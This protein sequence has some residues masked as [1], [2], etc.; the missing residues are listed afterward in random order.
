MWFTL[1]AIPSLVAT[2]TVW[3]QRVGADFPAFKS[4]CLQLSSL[5]VRHVPCPRD[6]GCDHLVLHRHDG[7][8]AVAACRCNP[9]VCPDLPLTRPDITTLEVCHTR[10]GYALCQAFGLNLRYAEL[11]VPNTFQFGA[12]STDAVPAVLTIQVQRP[13]FRRAVA[14]L[15]AVQRGRF[16][17]FAPTAD[18]LDA[19]ARAILENYGAAFF[20]LQ[21]HVILTE[22]GTLHA[23]RPPGELFARFN[24][25]PKD[26]DSDSAARIFAVVTKLDTDKPLKPPSLL[27]VFRLYC[28]EE[29]SSDQIARRCGTT[30]TTVLRRLALLQSRLAVHPRQLRRLSPHLSKIQDSLH[31]PHA[32]HIHPPSLLGE[33][34]GDD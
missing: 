33:E 23:T 15:A 6:C 13:Y 9:P 14:E 28:V 18:F 8:G 30:K 3:R 17:L 11:P 24:P 10:L 22:H 26:I 19:P 16:M 32:G 21:S 2:E 29:L 31:P 1:E 34:S 12:W 5:Q 27:T 20:D 7:A 25:Q 4:L